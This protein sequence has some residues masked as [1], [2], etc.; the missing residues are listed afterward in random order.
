MT[1]AAVEF[2]RRFMM[3]VLPLGFHKIRH[4]G[5]LA[6]KDKSVRIA[7]CKRLTNTLTVHAALPRKP[8]EVLRDIFG[9]KWGSC[10]RCGEGTLS[11][12]SPDKA[13]A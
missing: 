5:I 4:Y 9:G 2:I 6:S 10:P 8:L 11:G 13:T 7:L 1:V 12:A 3:H